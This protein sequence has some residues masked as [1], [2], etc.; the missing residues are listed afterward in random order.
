MS[1]DNFYSKKDNG[2]FA[3][4][5]SELLK[6]MPSGISKILDV[7]CGSGDF[8]AFLKTQN[9]YEI[10]GIEPNKSSTI[11]AQKKLDKVITGQFESKLTELNNQ[12]FDLICFNDVLEHL[13]NPSEVLELSKQFLSEPGYV[14]ASIPNIRY[15]RVILSLLRD[16]DFKYQSFGVMD[17]TH[18]RF[19]TKK[20]MIR[21]FE[22]C[23]F[24][25]LNIEGINEIKLPWFKSLFVNLQNDMKYPQ[26]AMLCKLK[27]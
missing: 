19:F 6:F 7:G 25:I 4:D 5:R 13:V 17:E 11:I 20:S 21:L 15:Y 18:L 24:E 16:K 26:F 27:N 9:N 12:K 22:N 3:N 2:Y 10:W 1:Y 23:N 14:M 8:G